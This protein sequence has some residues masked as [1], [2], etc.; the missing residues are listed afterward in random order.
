MGDIL[1]P[2]EEIVLCRGLLQERQRDTEF[3]RACCQAL[4]AAYHRR[5]R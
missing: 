2:D 5:C 4:G 3:F 1:T